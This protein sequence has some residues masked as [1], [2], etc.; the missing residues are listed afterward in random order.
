MI[1]GIALFD[2]CLLTL[3]FLEQ[4][5]WRNYLRIMQDIIDVQ[6]KAQSLTE[7]LAGDDQVRDLQ[8]V[9]D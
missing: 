2:E 9:D 1:E 6:C 3:L 7:K 4:E 8:K 5:H